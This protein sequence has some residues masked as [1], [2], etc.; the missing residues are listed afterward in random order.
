[1]N[2]VAL[3]Q[4]YTSVLERRK[5]F[6]GSVET[7]PFEGGW[8]GEAIFFV[9]VEQISEATVVD[10]RVQISPDGIH[11]VDEGSVLNS[12]SREGDR[13]VRVSHFGG[14]LRL[15]GNVSTR[16]GSRTPAATLTIHLALKQ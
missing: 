11:W 9:R 12:L 5:E 2:R 14:W 13:F 3:R 8:A 10:L 15:A 16:D 1:V 7:P 4:F 6:A